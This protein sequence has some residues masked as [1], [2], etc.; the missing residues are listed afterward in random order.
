MEPLRRQPASVYRHKRVSL[1]EEW[2]KK[3][4]YIYIMEYHS[5]IK[6]KDNMSFASK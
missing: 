1:T 4:W 2:I 6:N 3:M 5:A